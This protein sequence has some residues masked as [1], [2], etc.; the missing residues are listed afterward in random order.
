MEIAFR[1]TR[2]SI[3][4]GPEQDGKD[5]SKNGVKLWRFEPGIGVIEE[6]GLRLSGVVKWICVMEKK[7]VSCLYQFFVTNLKAD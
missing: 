1:F 5:V 7:T 2:N 6:G 4:P 3:R